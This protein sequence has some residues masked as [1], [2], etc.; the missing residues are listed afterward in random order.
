MICIQLDEI[1]KAV[2]LLINKNQKMSPHCLNVLNLLQSIFLLSL[3]PLLNNVNFFIFSLNLFFNVIPLL[4]G[5]GRLFS[6]FTNN[7]NS[8][9]K[10]AVNICFIYWCWGYHKYFHFYVMPYIKHL[11]NALHIVSFNDP[12]SSGNS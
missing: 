5:L 3:Y 4:I 11:C 10:M 8:H 6:V 7:L 12:N 9:I 1:V 2:P